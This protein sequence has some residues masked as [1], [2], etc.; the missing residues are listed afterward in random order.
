MELPTDQI[1]PLRKSVEDIF[2]SAEQKLTIVQLT[3]STGERLPCLVD[4]ATWLPVRLAT[5]WVVTYRRQRVQ[6]STLRDNLY[7]VS[8]L[9]RWAEVSELDLEALLLGGEILT[10]RQLAT[11]VN[12]LREQTSRARPVIS[13]NTLNK[14]LYAVEDFLLW[15]LDHAH[16]K[17]GQTNWLPVQAQRLQLMTMLRS[18]HFRGHPSKRIEPLTEAEIRAVR[19]VLAPQQSANEEWQFPKTFRATNA[20]R[21]WLMVEV[22][23]ELGLRIG[24]LLKLR[25]DSLPRGGQQMLLVRRYPDDPYDSRQHEP[26]VKTA[27]RGLPLSPALTSTLRVYVTSKPP[28]GRVSGKSPYLFVTDRG[29]PVSRGR[30]NDILQVVSQKSQVQ[31]LS[32]HRFRHTWAE[33][34]AVHLLEIPNGLDQLMYLGGWTSPNSPHRYMQNAVARQAQQSLTSWQQALYADEEP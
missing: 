8:K 13:P 22:A 10:V 20:L 15:A 31:P 3:L 33:Q 2:M 9:Y 24:E 12:Y 23:L 18:L 30:A 34:L 1:R 32:W 28:L 25:L 17:Q 27:E 26:A 5:R 14:H 7:A 21:N 11:F 4:A 19:Q 16:M 6:P 29:E